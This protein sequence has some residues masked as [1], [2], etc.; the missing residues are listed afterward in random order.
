MRLY[1]DAIAK[2][3]SAADAAPL[4]TGRAAAYLKLNLP[5]EALADAEHATELDPR[6]CQVRGVAPQVG[7]LASTCANAARVVLSCRVVRRPG[8]AV[9]E[10]CC[11]CTSTKQP[12]RHCSRRC[13]TLP[14]PTTDASWNTGSSRLRKARAA[15]ATLVDSEQA[16]RRAGERIPLLPLVER[17]NERT[18]TTRRCRA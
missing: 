15:D 7:Q 5:T 1:S 12:Q 3:G 10:H 11:R 17:T 13:V 18:N 4:Y 9:A 6:S 14:R 16:S 8:L 2:A